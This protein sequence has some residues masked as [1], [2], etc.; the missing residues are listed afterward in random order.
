MQLKNIFLGVIILLLSHNIYAQNAQ[1]R[2]F[3]YE[4]SSGEPVIF[5]NVYFLGTNLGAST[6]VNGY[7]VISKV[8]AGNYTLTVTA[9]GYD[10]I[11]QEIS[12]KNNELKSL[13]LYLEQASYTLDVVNVSAQRQ[14]ARTETRTA[15]ISVSPKQIS[16]LPS[17]G[18]QADLAQYLQVL[19]GVVFTGDQ[20][21]QLYIRGGSPVQ[22]KVM[23]DGMVI[24]NP[25]HSIG[26]FS[27]FETDII[28]NADVYTGGFNAEYGG[29]VSSVMDISTR[30]GNKKRLA[31][32]LQA[33]S[34]GAAVLLEGPLKKQ[35][36]GDAS[37][38]SFIFSAKNSY[39][40]QSS[41]ALY[42]Y[43]DE[44]IDS[45]NG[46][47]FNYLDLYGKVSL[48][49]SNGSKVNLFGFRF[50]DKVNNYQSISDFNWKAFGGGAN[51][52]IIPSGSSALIEAIIAY[53]DYKVALND[54]TNS[55]DSHISGFNGGINFTYFLGKNEFK[56][57]G[58]LS[59]FST[60]YGYQTGNGSNAEEKQNT[61]E[62]NLFAQYKVIIA[63]KVII[64]P[65]FRMQYYASLSEISPEPRLSLKY[66]I[67]DWLRFKAAWGLYSQNLVATASEMDVVNLFYG[68]LSGPENIPDTWMGKDVTSRLQKGQ[69]IIGGF[70]ID[71][72]SNLNL[73]IEG[74]YKKFGQLT[75]VNRNKLFNTSGSST[76]SYVQSE[77]SDLQ[78]LDYMIEEGD[79]EGIDFTLRYDYRNFYFWAAYSFAYVNR[80]G[81][82][83]ENGTMELLDYNPFYDRRHN[84]NLLGSVK[85]GA[86]EEW[87]VS[88]RWNFGTGFPFTPTAGYYEQ[89]NFPTIGGE[90][91]EQNGEF[92]VL[93]GKLN[94]KR[95][96]TYHRMDFN[97]K[98][99]FFVG[100]NSTLQADISVTNIYDRK[101][102]FYVDRL[103]NQNVYQL[104]ILPSFG[105]TF[106][107]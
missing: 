72:L 28:R 6:D 44:K 9:L 26:L 98:R 70:E 74:Y 8:P 29:R 30:D 69:H 21:G 15:V 102:L 12:L 55:R 20:G 96:P 86:A 64:E 35:K 60:T 14:E 59:G 24:Y 53:S 17:V 34:F 42:G 88:A 83:T 87:E 94:S 92:T 31:G 13:N 106:R 38:T 99:M 52:V 93:Y 16:Q 76:E 66:N 58:E 104:P 77:V 7:Y 3:V 4:E 10:T 5:T 71:I 18:G 49:T 105:L 101:N 1:I 51:L 19:P 68:F 54:P 90:Y 67:T 39:L 40:E 37:S 45:D 57:G 62:L 107:F 78:W 56:W 27:V 41:Q 73:N 32:K 97:L 47:P 103:T 61:T 25:F 81:Y 85:F 100:E 84:L 95:L 2:G 91:V 33:T 75:N 65:G 43:I 50:D 79:A 89:L 46:L 11:A 82:V 22:N 63:E 80:T 36:D 48:N 23:M